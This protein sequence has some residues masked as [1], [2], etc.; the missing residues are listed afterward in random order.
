MRD[1]QLLMPWGSPRP[2]FR[3]LSD[4]LPTG[5]SV[6][7]DLLRRSLTNLG[8]LAANPL[9]FLIVLTYGLVWF[10]FKRETLDW[11]GV[12]TLATWFMTLVIQRA[13]HRDTQAIQ[14]KLDELLHAQSQARN[15]MTRIDDKEPED[16]ERHREQARKRD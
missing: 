4:R 2:P 8:V 10:L 5:S 9:A 6:V 16:I 11:H 7:I 3:T 15:S 1:R 13:E 14:A 12:A